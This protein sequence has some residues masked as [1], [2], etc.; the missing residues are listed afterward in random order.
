LTSDYIYLLVQSAPLHD[1]GKIG[2]PDRLLVEP[3]ALDEGDRAVMKTHTRLG[4]EVLERAERDREHP[5]PFLALAKELARWHH[6]EWAGG[7]YPDGLAGDAIPVSARLMALADAFDTLISSRAGAKALSLD[8]ARDALADGRGVRFD[9]DVTDAFLANFDE[10]VEIVE[11][12]P[13]SD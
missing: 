7:G 4:G 12:Y 13:Q 3:E 10:F 1:I 8:E 2:L 9:P 5:A 11:K 6:E